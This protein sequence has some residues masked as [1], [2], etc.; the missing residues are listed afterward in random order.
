M[1]N[2][3]KTHQYRKWIEDPQVGKI[4][5]DYG[6]EKDARVWIKDVP[7]KEYTRAQEGIGN[8]VRYTVRRFKGPQEIIQA[9]FGHG[10]DMIPNTINVKP[11]HCYATNGTSTRYVCWGHAGTVRD[12]VWAALSIAVSGGDRPAIVVTTRDGETIDSPVRELHS[13]LAEHCRID[14]SYLHR[15]LIV[16]P[17]YNQPQAH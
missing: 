1:S 16:N 4:L 11:N 9:A 8:Y 2:P 17:E 5:L 13:A 12:L 10:W 14:L 7:M 3:E 6:P 15:E